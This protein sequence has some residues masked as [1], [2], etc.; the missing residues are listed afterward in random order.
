MA[1]RIGGD[2]RYATA[3]LIATEVVSVLRA[4]GQTPGG[5][6]L[7]SG[8][9]ASGG[10]DALAASFLAGHLRAPLLLTARGALPAPT[11][12]ALR[13]LLP[14]IAPTQGPPAVHVM[15]GT[16]V[17]TA[18]VERAVAALGARVVRVA[19]DDRYAT[20]AAA[21]RLGAST[22]QTYA[23][24]GGG[25]GGAKRTAILA[26]GTNPA[27]ALSAGPLACAAGVP[28]LLTQ[29]DAL[30]DAT[31]SALAELQVRQVVTLGG[32]AA[33]ATSVLDALVG[34]GLSVLPVRGDDRFDTAAVLLALACAPQLDGT[35]K[36]DDVGGFGIPF[37]GAT[38]GYLANGVRFPD[39]LA[40]GPLAGLA[41]RPLF[42]TSPTALA[43]AT[44]SVLPGTGVRSLIGVGRSGALP[45]AVLD[46]AV[47]VLPR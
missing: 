13:D 32:P 24:L 28:L 8:E 14:R 44:R 2:D 5:V 47:A 42:V 22:A 23:L 9:D 16:A 3:A 18:D 25:S 31:R 41:R 27:D 36:D 12:T 34:L 35:A 26:S 21:A 10:I 39:A 46:A 15:G 1:D 40:C 19:G 45:D 7:A 6:L 29:R 43:E 33:I 30:P 20:A 4:A 11:A 38:T 37:D 17:V